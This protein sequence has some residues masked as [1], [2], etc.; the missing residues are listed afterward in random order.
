MKRLSVVSLGLFL[1]LAVTGTLWSQGVLKTGMDSPLQIV[2]TRKYL[3]HTVRLNFEDGAKKFEAGRLGDIQANGAAAALAAK[4]MPPLFRE[5]H[6]TAY[7][8]QGKFFKGAE[9]EVFEAACEAMRAAA[10]NVRISAEKVDK[11]GVMEAMGA[12]QQSCGTCHNAYRGS[13]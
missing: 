1:V 3:M 13:F 5:R 4:V 10:Q 9:P 8:G 6:E 11:A 2:K 12:L 7:D